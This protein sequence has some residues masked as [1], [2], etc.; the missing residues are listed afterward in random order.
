MTDS[1]ERWRDFQ[2]KS[3]GP[4]VPRYVFATGLLDRE[5][6]FASPAL[7]PYRQ[8][9]PGRNQPTTR[10]L[11]TL[12]HIRVVLAL[13]FALAFTTAASAGQI[14]SYDSAHDFVFSPVGGVGGPVLY[15]YGAYAF[16]SPGGLPGLNNGSQLFGT[17]GG[18]FSAPA[19]SN[20]IGVNT[21]TSSTATINPFFAGGPLSGSIESQGL[22]QLSI[23]GDLAGE[24]NAAV[25]INGG[26]GMARGNI[27]FKPKVALQVVGPGVFLDPGAIDP[28]HFNVTDLLNGHVTSGSLFEVSS[29]LLGQGLWTWQGGI[30]TL[31]AQ[32]FDFAINMDSPFTVQQGT[33]DVSVR[34]GLITASSGTG[35][36][37]GVFPAVGTS[38][39]F[40]VAL[41]S[42]FS[43]DY[44]LGN[45]G[46]DPLAVQFDFSDSG[47]LSTVPEPS[48]IVSLVLGMMTG[49]GIFRRR[50]RGLFARPAA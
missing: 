31:S 20:A 4:A 39:T 11:P 7:A 33:A 2:G 10:R 27:N 1:R 46:A 41:P 14:A 38:G 12:S 26:A 17:A 18:T 22:G 36:F 50:I 49:A 5:P 40:S 28:I 30:F 15:Q 13:F 48:A 6:C 23:P 32:D 35:M 45:F 34:D 16:S 9:F 42:D 43:L 37:S 21:F 29:H 47:S 3:I 24:S 25:V 8:L 19:V 44:N